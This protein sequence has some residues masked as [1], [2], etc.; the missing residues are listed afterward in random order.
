MNKGMAVFAVIEGIP[1]H[2]AEIPMIQDKN[3]P[4]PRMWK[5]IGGTTED[6]ESASWTILREVNEEIGINIIPPTEKDIVLKKELQKYIFMAF[7]AKYYN[8][9]IRQGSEIS[10]LY[11][12]T[13]EE[14]VQMMQ[15]GEIVSNHAEALKKYLGLTGQ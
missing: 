5:L 9:S 2:E 15:N 7:K 3:K 11:F 13:R 10:K 14:I 4:L 8:G 12:F 1:K 6:G